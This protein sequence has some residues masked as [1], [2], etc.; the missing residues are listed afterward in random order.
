MASGTR[1]SSDSDRKAAQAAGGGVEHDD[2]TDLGV[3]EQKLVR[4]LDL[5]LI[6]L[7]MLLC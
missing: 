4:K 3:E 6:P 5:H 2:G 7:V 1:K